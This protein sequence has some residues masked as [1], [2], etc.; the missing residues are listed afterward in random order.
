MRRKQDSEC[1]NGEEFDRIITRQPCQCTDNDYECDMN[2]VKNQAGNCEPAFSEEN[3]AE[4]FAI[5]KE[6]QCKVRGFHYDVTGYV[7]IPENKCKGGIRKDPIKM[8]CSGMG[9][10]KS[11]L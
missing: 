6:R 10:A 11:F 3:R 1:F 2:Y 5:E 7:K 9:F 8:P 4:L